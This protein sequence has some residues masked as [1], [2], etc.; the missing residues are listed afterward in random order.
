MSISLTGRLN[1]W[2][3]VFQKQQNDC[4]VSHIEMIYTKLKK[5]QDKDS[6]RL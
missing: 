2:I 5:S 4:D 3:F 6:K 1:F